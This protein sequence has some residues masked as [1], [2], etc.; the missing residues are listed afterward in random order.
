MDE[1]EQ[2]KALEKRVSELENEVSRIKASMNTS[3]ERK[4]RDLSEPIG[5]RPSETNLL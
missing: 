1:N 5:A 3:Q 4:V 2:I